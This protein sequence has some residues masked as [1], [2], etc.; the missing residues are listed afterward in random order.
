MTTEESENEDAKISTEESTGAAA[1][2]ERLSQGVLDGLGGLDKAQV[3]ISMFLIAVVGVIAFSNAVNLP[4]HL[5]DQRFIVENTNLH[6]LETASLAWDAEKLR[7]LAALSIAANWT[8][9][10]GSAAGF[11]FINILLHVLSGICVYLICRRI[12][13]PGTPEAVSMVSGM[14]FVTHPALTQAVNY[15]PSR[16]ILLGTLFVLLSVLLYLHEMQSESTR[17]YRFLGL[18]LLS[19]AMAWACDAA[20]WILPLLLVLVALATSRRTPLS[21]QISIIAIYGV[22]LAGLIVVQ[23]GDSVAPASASTESLPGVAQA[24]ALAS[25]ASPTLLPRGLLVEHAPDTADTQGVPWLW[26]VSVAVGLV[27]LRFAPVPGLA[28]LWY[29]LAILGPGTFHA[30]TTF[31]E[32][33]L[34]LPL[35]GLVLL[36]AWVLS[37]FDKSTVRLM[38]GLACALLIMAF[39]ALSSTRNNQ[40][41]SDAIWIQAN[42]A[43][44]QC[45]GPAEHRAQFYLA[46]GE[47]AFLTLARGEAGLNP[48]ALRQ[49]ALGNFTLAQ[50]FFE[51]ASETPAP[52][53]ELWYAQAKIQNY[54]G[55]PVASLAFLQSGLRVD[56]SHEDSLRFRAQL[57]ADRADATGRYADQRSAVD[58]FRYADGHLDWSP[59]MV[60]RYAL[61]ASRLGNLQLAMTLLTNL[62]PEERELLPEQTLQE[63][64]QKIQALQSIQS[65]L[66]STLQDPAPGAALNVVRA[67]RLHIEG[68][69]LASNYLLREALQQTELT[70][71]MWTLIGVNSAKMASIEQFL[72]DWPE[73]PGADSGADDWRGLAGACASSGEWSVALTVF[74]YAVDL[75]VGERTPLVML[76]ELAAEFNDPQR[77]AAYYQQAIDAD[78]AEVSAWLGMADLLLNQGQNAAARHF[79]TQAEKNGA[80]EFAINARK[81]RAGIGDVDE[82]GIERSIIR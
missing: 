44:P 75:F 71:Q 4:Y 22:L 47:T 19:F 26:L 24:R 1:L 60:G 55:D 17:R 38:T 23:S 20:V 81:E 14:M 35:A 36:P 54:L 7:P 79:I 56:S 6:R 42:E 12:L 27:L 37:V 8:L 82:H 70:P 16:G 49:E 68:Q 33:R 5:N 77:A 67:Q 78:V 59:E 30:E 80:P 61:Q 53:V 9:G 40:W 74:E 13:A 10:G 72:S 50:A 43:C 46:Q 63:I 73:G 2:D 76:A 25:F 65:A 21:K 58:H 15:L 29:L 28:L 34:Y 32:A 48:D 3:A 64:S 62:Q 11:H 66:D 39:I 69:Y 52:S 45:P 18:S 51:T 41:R 57:S 31:D